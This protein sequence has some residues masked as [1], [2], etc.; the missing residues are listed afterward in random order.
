MWTLLS[1]RPINFHTRDQSR[2][3]RVLLPTGQEDLGHRPPFLVMI[4]ASRMLSVQI[5][6]KICLSLDLNIKCKR[7]AL[8]RDHSKWSVMGSR[9]VIR[10]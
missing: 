10:Y 5:A 9:P 8:T 3:S 6:L 1:G 7:S 4:F 2:N